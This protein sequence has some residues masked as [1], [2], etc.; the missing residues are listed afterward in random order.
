MAYGECR[1]SFNKDLE[2]SRIV[3]YGLDYILEKYINRKWTIDDLL[4]TERFCQSHNAGKTPFPWPKDLFTKV[5]II[6]YLSSI[7]YHLDCK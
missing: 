6:Y 2:D 7:A 3:F 4:E 5:S 1:T